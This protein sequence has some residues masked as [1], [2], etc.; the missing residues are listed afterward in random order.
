MTNLSGRDPDPTQPTI[1]YRA[2]LSRSLNVIPPPSEEEG[3]AL[4]CDKSHDA[5]A[6]TSLNC[7]DDAYQNLLDYHSEGGE[8]AEVKNYNTTGTGANSNPQLQATTPVEMETDAAA[9]SSPEMDAVYHQ[10]NSTRSA[11]RKDTLTSVSPDNSFGKTVTVQTL[12]V[13]SLLDHEGLE[14]TFHGSRIMRGNVAV[15]ESIS[16][17]FDPT[18]LT[19]LSCSTEHYIAQKGPITVLFSDQNFPAL[20]PCENGQCINIVRLENA[21]LLELF[22]LA[23][24]IFGSTVLAEGSIFMF[25]SASCL[26]R[27]R[28]SLDARDWTE[29]VA[30][31]N[32]HWRGIHV[33]PL[34]PVILSECPGSIVRELSELATWYDRMYDSNPQG[35]RETWSC[36]VKSMENCSV[37]ITALDAMDT[38]KLVLP[39]SLHV[40]TLDHT[41]TFCSNSSCP[42]I[43]KGLSK[44]NKSDLL[45]TLLT[46]IFENYRAC[47]R[48]EVYLAR[49]DVAKTISE[50]NVQKVVLSGAS[51]LRHSVPHFADP[52]LSFEDITTPGWVAS[53]E[54]I[55]K[56]KKTIEAKTDNVDGYVFDLL[57]NSSVRFEQFDGTTSL[58]FKSNGRFHLGGK[59]TVTPASV[60]KKVVDNVIPALKAKG[61]K[62]C[63]VVPPTP[64]YLFSR[65]C[66]DSSHCTNANDSNFAEQ[67][68]SGFLRQRTE[69][70][71]QLVQSGLSNFKVLDSGCTTDC[72]ATASIPERLAALKKTTWND[73]VHHTVDGYKN[74]AQRSIACL[75]SLIENPKTKTKNAYFWRG[76]RS[77][78]G[79]ALPR[80]HT[81][82]VTA[83]VPVPPHLPIASGSRGIPPR[84]LHWERMRGSNIG[85]SRS[86]HPYRRW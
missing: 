16:C 55:E 63:V 45:G 28:T 3:L 8:T 38:Y 18:T 73:S 2:E 34:V 65:C 71:R 25:G 69:L 76:F 56:L 41:V 68:L 74:L 83:S 27:S 70:I 66:S 5:E 48:P 44:D 54:S 21:N 1:D 12:S 26:G 64:R 85:R 4:L 80:P 49:A 82:S 11:L 61:N 59:V 77:P 10:C 30:R 24:E 15:N 58:P 22:E 79:S 86:F 19:C 43:F 53:P 52:G 51:N 13:G 9:G 29:V 7:Y 40:R 36:L 20:M 42:V 60:F 37:G 33:C 72:S 32:N 67:M 31:S 50:N 62:P 17:S 57:G 81:A 78:V 84:A 6:A 14:K 35:L 23:K 75:K 39:S 46:N 47:S